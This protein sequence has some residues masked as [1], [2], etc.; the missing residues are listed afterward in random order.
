MQPYWI[1]MTT[2][3]MNLV[4]ACPYSELA[5]LDRPYSVSAYSST[6]GPA[7]YL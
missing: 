7:M 2:V 5:S 1:P 4:T 6:S 3:W